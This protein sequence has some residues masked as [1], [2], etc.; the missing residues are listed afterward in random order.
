MKDK[1]KTSIVVDRRLWEEFK[2]KVAGEKGLK[3]LSE[4]IER[5]IEDELSELLIIE[6]FEKQL[7]QRETTLTISPIKPR[8]QTDAGKIVRELRESRT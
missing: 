4:A 8:I 5:A 7:E 1:V 3:M 6:A 2:S